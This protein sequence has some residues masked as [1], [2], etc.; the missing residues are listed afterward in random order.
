MSGT[1]ERMM[2]LRSVLSVISAVSIYRAYAK[3]FVSIPMLK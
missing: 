2:L 3:S 1:N